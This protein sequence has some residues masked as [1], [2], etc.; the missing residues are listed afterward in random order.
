MDA[1]YFVLENN[2]EELKKYLLEAYSFLIKGYDLLIP[3]IKS[4]KNY[5]ENKLRDELVMKAKKIK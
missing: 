3:E 1:K 2:T 5:N 4:F